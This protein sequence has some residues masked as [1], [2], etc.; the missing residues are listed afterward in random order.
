MTRTKEQID[1]KLDH[2][3]EKMHQSARLSPS[4]KLRTQS[5]MNE[6]KNELGREKE[7][8]ER[9]I[10]LLSNAE[11]HTQIEMS[12]GTVIRLRPRTLPEE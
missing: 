11:V 8:C 7:N 10:E 1:K 4:E 6:L 5:L 9:E 3:I 12:G 2:L